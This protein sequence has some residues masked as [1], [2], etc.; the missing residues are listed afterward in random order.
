MR[1]AVLGVLQDAAAHDWESLA[2]RLVCDNTTTEARR[3]EKLF[4]AFAEARGR[5]R[6]DPEGRSTKHTHGLDAPPGGNLEIAQVLVDPE[7]AND[8]EA[9]FAVDITASREAGRVMLRL[10]T[11]APIG[12]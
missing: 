7:E 6:L 8:W 11:V 12:T 10:E 1:V 5:L 2:A 9:R 4:T 3:T